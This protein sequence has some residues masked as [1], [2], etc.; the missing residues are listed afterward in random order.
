M[1]EPIDGGECHR[2][3]DEDLVPLREW[4][5]RGDRDALALVAFA[6]E[7]EEHRRLSLIA[8]HVAEIIQ[9]EE[10][11]SIEFGQFLRQAQIASSR[12]KPLH[13]IA[14][15][16]EEHALSRVD[17]GVPDATEQVT[18]PASGRPEGEQIDAAIEPFVPFAQR[19]DVCARERRH[20][21]EVETGEPLVGTE[22]GGCTMALVAAHLSVGHLV[23]EQSFQQLPRRPPFAIG[24]IAQLCGEL[25]N[26]RQT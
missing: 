2:W 26:G 24:L 21:G 10:V 5:V 15:T 1:N 3:I 25:P 13:Q 7:F 11:E 19:R 4:G 18:L 17:K 22:A 23:L 8:S 6:D 14:A 20:G 9:N 12:L 16:G